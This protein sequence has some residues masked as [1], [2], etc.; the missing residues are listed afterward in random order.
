M[1]AKRSIFTCRRARRNFAGRTLAFA[2]VQLFYMLSAFTLLFSMDHARQEQHPLRNFYLRRL[3]RIAP[4]FYV[5]IALHAVQLHVLHFASI[6]W[7]RVLL[8]VLFLNGLSPEAINTVTPGGWSIAVE[9]TFY[10]ILPFLYMHLRTVGRCLLAS[11]VSAVTFWQLS[12][13]LNHAHPGEMWTEYLT[14][15]WFPVEF[16]VFLLGMG[17]YACWKSFLQPWKASATPVQRQT[18]SAVLLV[19]MPLPLLTPVV[20]QLYTASVAAFCLILAASLWSWRP[21]ENRLV[22]M[23]GRVSFSLYLLHFF[24]ISV[25]GVAVLHLPPRWRL[26]LFAHASGHPQVA[27]LV[28]FVLITACSIPVAMLSA[29][30]IEQPGMAFGRRLIAALEG[31]ESSG[32]KRPSLVDCLRTARASQAR[33]PLQGDAGALKR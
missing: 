26:P 9:M 31:R 16:P 14:T 24:V 23:M 10:L 5:A 21:L 4:L 27:V 15:F 20:P 33:R 32:S 25:F 11:T 17:V 12:V 22:I 1:R 7:P 6:P 8:G 19:L 13:F 18:M 3:F 28:T 30:L 2:G 29:R